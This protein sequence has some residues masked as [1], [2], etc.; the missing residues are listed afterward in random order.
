MERI[1]GF[2][3][4]GAASSHLQSS[5]ECTLS[6]LPAADRATVEALF[7]KRGT[8]LNPRVGY[9]LTR[10]KGSTSETIEAPEGAVPASIT[11]CVK[12]TLK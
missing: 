9:R 1:G 11:A 2:A 4:F 6:E 7:A 10:T 3:G 12:D 8:A 5:G